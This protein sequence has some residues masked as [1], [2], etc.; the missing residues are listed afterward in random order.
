MATTKTLIRESKINS[1]GKCT[2]YIQYCHNEQTALFSTAVKIPPADFDPKRGRIRKGYVGYTSLN[3]LITKKE[4]EVIKAYSELMLKDINPSV[5]EVRFAMK[6]EVRVAKENNFF[7]LFKQYVKEKKQTVRASTARHFPVTQGKLE[8]FLKAEGI[9]NITI[10]RVNYDLLDKFN[11]FLLQS[12][13]PGSANNH[14]K[15]VKTFLQKKYWG[16]EYDSLDFK[17][18]KLNEDNVRDQRKI[19]LTDKELTKLKNKEMPS[20]KLEKVRDLFVLACC[21]G[22]RFSDLSNLRK[23]HVHNDVISINTVKTNKTLEIP[24]FLFAKEIIEKYNGDLPKISN[25]KMNEYL[26][27]VCEIAEINSNMIIP[28]WKGKDRKDE[29]FKKFQLISS[30]TGKKTFV[31]LCVAAGVDIHRVASITGNDVNSLKHYYD[32]ETSEKVRSL[33]SVEDYFNKQTVD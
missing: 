14:I 16:G 11:S 18:I 31:M 9:S 8:S 30:H 13:A 3:G 1:Q 19:F 17:N 5:D 20:D 25:Q 26:K 29:V 22:L 7:I 27:T 28:T 24:L 23:E 12:L 15:R 2:V 21:T 10:E 32:I 4:G 6:G 33:K